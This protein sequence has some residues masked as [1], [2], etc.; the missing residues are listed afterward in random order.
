M[1]GVIIEPESQNDKTLS[2]KKS[3]EWWSR[4]I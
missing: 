3:G 1:K 2:L 4:D